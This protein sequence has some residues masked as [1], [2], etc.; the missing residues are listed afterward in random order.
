[1]NRLNQWRQFLLGK[2]KDNPEV[3][4]IYSLNRHPKRKALAGEEDT[5]WHEFAED[6]QEAVL[7]LDAEFFQDLADAARELRAGR[8]I[9]AEAFFLARSL[10]EDA[11]REGKAPTEIVKGEIRDQ[12]IE[13]WA[14]EISDSKDGPTNEDWTR[15]KRKA[16]SV[17]WP[18]VYEAA[19]IKDA[20][21]RPKP[22]KRIG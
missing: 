12:I 3:G 8:T 21:K 15:A 20:A 14:N 18:S 11:E 22:K 7:E 6:V 10:V 13:I 17:R 1:M 4:R 9:R 5:R 19:G 16:K 2:E